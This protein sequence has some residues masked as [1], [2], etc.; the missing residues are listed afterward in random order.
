[1]I[2]GYTYYSTPW[3]GFS[4]DDVRVHEI[5]RALSRESDMIIAFTLTSS[6]CSNVVTAGSKLVYVGIPRPLYAMLS[7]L[8][9]W[10][11]HYDLNPLQKLTHYI[12]ELYLCIILKKFLDALRQKGFNNTILYLFG[13]MSLASFFLKRILGLGRHMRM[14]YDVLGNYAQTLHLR[15]RR[16]LSQLIRYGLYLALHKLQLKESDVTVYPSRLDEENAK[17]MFNM[18]RTAV[19]P[20]PFPVCYENMEEYL[21]YRN[22]SR[23]DDRVF[24]VL[25]A[26]GKGGGNE[27]VVRKTI[28]IFNELD[29]RRF[30]LVITGPWTELRDL[31]KCSSIEITGV[32]S[33]EKLKKFLAAAD[34]GLAPIFSHVAGTYLKTLAYLAA[35]LDII[36]SPWAFTGLDSSWFKN[37]RIILVRNWNELKHESLKYLQTPHIR[38][39]RSPVLCEELKDHYSCIKEHLLSR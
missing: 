30:K 4:G 11:N 36:G 20:N 1:M 19:I 17:K 35:D 38:K 33:H 26:G 18:Q 6:K 21:K 34:V 25:L 23:D 37:R 29:P 15:S 31:P 9:N 8:L 5:L 28:E 32:I 24:F 12:D 16:N 14:V 2:I 7:T 10:R 13:S 27:E 39:E 3:R 22:M